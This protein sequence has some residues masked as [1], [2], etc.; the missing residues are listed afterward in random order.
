MTD[1][2]PTLA[3]VR[4]ACERLRPYRCRTPVLR[5]TGFLA[6]ATFLKCENL[7]LTGAFKLRGAMNALLAL[8]EPV[9]S[10]GVATHSS[11]NHGA[12]LAYAAS[13]LG[14]ESHVVVPSTISEH[15][16]RAIQQYSNLYECEPCVT[17][18]EATLAEVA[19]RTGSTVIHPYDDAEVIAGQ[20]T[21]TLELLE[22]VPD[23]EVIVA[24][25][26]GGGLMSGTAIAAHGVNPKIAIV[27]VEPELADDARQSL[28][29][30]QIVPSSPTSNRTIA[31]GLRASLCP[32][33]FSII[34]EHVEEILIASER[35]IIDAMYLAWNH[36]KIVIEP[37]SAVALAVLWREGRFI[38]KRV[39]VIITGGNVSLDHL[40]WQ[41]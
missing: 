2:I 28:A 30:G 4:L 29:R 38:G 16:R 5:N 39:G 8:S 20:G 14:I 12:A 41:K 33:T 13:R 34:R 36:M 10:R 32:R 22:E 6:A 15:K 23:L 35:E 19:S 7:Q 26:S 17:A 1:R 21:A 40:P 31:D 18:R 25:I 24:P 9:R 3:D 27:G 37:S 11:G